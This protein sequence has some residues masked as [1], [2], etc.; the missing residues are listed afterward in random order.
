M[1]FGLFNLMGYRDPGIPTRTILM[2]VAE[3]TRLAEQ[4]GF[5]MAW[6]AEH[7]FSNYCVCPSPLLMAAHCAG[8]TNRIRL[9][10]GVLVLPLYRPSRL[11]AE[12]A[13][14]HALSGGRLVLGV[15][16]G[17]QPYEFERFGVDL[18][19]SKE[20]TI[21]L[22]EMVRRGLSEEFFEFSG[23]YFTQPRTHI[24]PRCAGVLPEI[25]VAGEAPAMQRFAAR[26][27]LASIVSAR[28]GGA[29]DLAE[30]RQRCEQAV[31]AEGKDPDTLRIGVLRYAC[32]TDS[33]REAEAY[34]EN[35][36]YQLRLA[37]A[38]RNR[39]EVMDGHM[40]IDRPHAGD[41][42]IEQIVDSLMIGDPETCAA[43]AV[44]DI[45]S[46]RPVHIALYFQVGNYEHARAMRSMERFAEEVI[47][48]VERELGPLDSAGA[49]G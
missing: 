19:Q 46:M 28:L 5:G 44:A 42:P 49:R 2:Q 27:D 3:Q 13:M 41:L 4:V 25:W 7:H 30:L 6:F 22:I 1:E 43:R 17:Y 15:G 20:M 39:A 26:H 10:T 18:A 45:R 14:V 35:V 24:A 47:P 38:L 40:L 48:L 31:A 36:R 11:I 33:R 29:E 34:A 37:A 8:L 23:R 9:A 12:I 16:S 32:V 21:E